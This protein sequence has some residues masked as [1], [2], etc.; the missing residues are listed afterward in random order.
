MSCSAFRL[1]QDWG[2]ATL[3]SRTRRRC[4]RPAELAPPPARAYDHTGMMLLWSPGA[5]GRG[6]RGFACDLE[7]VTRFAGSADPS[8]LGPAFRIENWVATEVVAKLT[9]VPVLALL[10]SGGGVTA[11][12][13]RLQELNL[14]PYGGSGRARIWITPSDDG[15]RVA[16]FGILHDTA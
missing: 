15:L 2:D 6:A 8:F 4:S 12:P 16:A 14:R 3:M 5:S 1:P 11:S 13:R 7:H 9:G 10:K